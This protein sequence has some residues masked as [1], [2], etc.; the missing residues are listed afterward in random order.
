[1]NIMNCGDII[2]MVD[3]EAHITE[4]F[5]KYLIPITKVIS[6]NDEFEEQIDKLSEITFK[7][8]EEVKI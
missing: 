8:Y 4:I 3:F 2:D 5:E 7:D 1:M 6:C